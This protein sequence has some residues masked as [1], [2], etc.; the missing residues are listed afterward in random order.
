MKNT[1]IA[2][3]IFICPLGA[4]AQK[5]VIYGDVG[6][7]FAYLYPGASVTYNHN[8][9]KY[10]GI[11][12]GAQGYVF[13][14]TRTTPH[15]FTP[16]VF[17]DI[18]FNIRPK[19]QNQFFVYMDFGMDIYKHDPAYWREGN[20]IYNTTKDNGFYTGLG[21]GYF[22]RLT[23]R[24]AGPYCSVKMISNGYSAEGLTLA[25]NQKTTEHFADGTFVLSF[26]FKF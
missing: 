15:K 24:G 4:T 11:G 6:L 19:K 14:T 18:R 21:L 13:H 5:D 2:L 20:Y 7:C 12:V 23:D 10:I 22:L 16:A 17:A 25:T 9:I 26:G 1:L 3:L 8:F